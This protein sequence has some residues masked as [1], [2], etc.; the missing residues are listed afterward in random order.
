M[1]Y[2]GIVKIYMSHKE[3]TILGLVYEDDNYHFEIK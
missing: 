3:N 1:V 2:S